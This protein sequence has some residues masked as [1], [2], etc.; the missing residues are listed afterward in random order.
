MASKALNWEKVP[1]TKSPEH[2]TGH[3]T[4]RAKVPGGWLVAVW[5]T[6]GATVWG[7][8]VTFLPDRKHKWGRPLGK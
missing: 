8:G 6:K 1:E 4:T 2:V 3:L 7:G 5:A